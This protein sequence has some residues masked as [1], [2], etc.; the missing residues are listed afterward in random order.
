MKSR[1]PPLAFLPTVEAAARLGS[2]KAA[3][4]LLGLTPSAISQQ[5]RAVEEA[6][7]RALFTRTGRCVVPTP[8]GERYL[9]DVRAALVALEA[10][11][12]RLAG[13]PSKA[14][15][16]IEA[17]SFVAYEFLV[18]RLAALQQRFPRFEVSLECRM[19]FSELPGSKLDATIRVGSGVWPDVVTRS[20]GALSTAIVCSPQ[21]ARRIERTE[22]LA[23]L[24]I[25]EM[26]SFAERG[27]VN[28]LRGLGVRIDPARVLTM[29]SY[30]ETVRAAEAGLGVAI[31][32][33]P[34]TTEWVNAGRLAVPLALRGPALSHIAL[35]HRHEDERFPWEE[36]AAW[37]RSQLHELPVLQP[38]VHAPQRLES[39]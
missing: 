13:P 39:K 31:G 36:L 25:L 38:G 30:F 32:V 11:G 9:S 28:M 24:P 26:R 20:L 27:L 37:L 14:V 19:A 8:E 5:V 22:D 2:F 12:A 1:L 10:A 29:E 33:F 3:A 34:L 21:L 23:E 7:G 16:R 15:M 35:L 6:L 18:P 17:E 4:E